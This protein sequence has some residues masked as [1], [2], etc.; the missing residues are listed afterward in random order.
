MQRRCFS[1]TACILNLLV[2][3]ASCWRQLLLSAIPFTTIFTAQMKLWNTK[4]SG[5]RRHKNAAWVCIDAC[6]CIYPP[7]FLL[8][9]NRYK[10]TLPRSVVFTIPKSSS[11]VIAFC[12]RHAD[13]HWVGF[14]LL[15]VRI[16]LCVSFCKL[17]I[18]IATP[19]NSYVQNQMTKGG[20]LALY[21]YGF[22]TSENYVQ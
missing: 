14:A 1:S 12:T 21:K 19:I 6:L 22:V 13:V 16:C 7:L 15:C 4:L 10:D 2:L 8:S 9:N 18:P 3:V 11:Q 20:L 5:I 17:Q